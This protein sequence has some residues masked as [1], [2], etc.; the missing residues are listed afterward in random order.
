ME[1][2][3][4]T[5]LRAAVITVSDSA[6]RGTREDLSGPAV[7]KRLGELG[8]SVTLHE[9]VPDEVSEICECL[10]RLAAN[11]SCEAVFTTGG[12]GIAARDVT[13]E[14]TRAVVEREIP[15]ISELMRSEGLQFTPRSVLSRGIAGILGSTLIVNFPGSPR[16]AVQSLESIAHL[17][18]HVVDLL[19]GKTEHEPGEE[20]TENMR[21]SVK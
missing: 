12:T 15:G 10:V 13:P 8:W 19:K 21:T 20:T 6:F 16:G 4:L 1:A 11:S 7:A 9:V 17:L 14:A 3:I 18:P 2:R 5:S